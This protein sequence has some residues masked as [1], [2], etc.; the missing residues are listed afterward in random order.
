MKI[1][2]LTWTAA[3]IGLASLFAASASAQDG[4][5]PNY[6]FAQY[7]TPAGASQVN[8]AMY[9]APLPVPP[10]VGHSYYTYQPLMPHEMLYTHSRNYY[11]YY[12]GNDAFY[13][14]GYRYPCGGALNKTTVRWTS[15]CGANFMGNF[16]GMTMPVARLRYGF[17][18]HRYHMTGNYGAGGCATGDC[19]NGCS[20]N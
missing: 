6:H 18:K 7:Y 17:A 10:Q 11:N 1:H 5:L 14:S 12:A 2:R 8:A 15:G 20:G 16:P 3:I 19:A 9:P 4:T 13:H